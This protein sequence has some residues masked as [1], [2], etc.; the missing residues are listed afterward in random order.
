MGALRDG[1][2]CLVSGFANGKTAKDFDATVMHSE[3][4]KLCNPTAGLNRLSGTMDVFVKTK[5]ILLGLLAL[6][7]L[8]W[9]WWRRRLERAALAA[10]EAQKQKLDGFIKQTLEVE[11]EQMDVTDPESLRPYLRRVTAIKQ[12]GAPGLTGKKGSAA[13]SCSRYSSPQM[14]FG[15]ER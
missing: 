7:I 5:E 9:N 8:V 12:E 2:A 6:S 14:R 3:G 10:D 4:C 1:P 15:S 13:T 11:L